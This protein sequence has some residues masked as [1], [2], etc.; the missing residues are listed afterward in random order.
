MRVPKKLAYTWYGLG[1]IF[2]GGVVIWG[3]ISDG[4]SDMLCLGIPALIFGVVMLIRGIYY[5]KRDGFS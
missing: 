3:V 4:D 5:F 1:G 2:I